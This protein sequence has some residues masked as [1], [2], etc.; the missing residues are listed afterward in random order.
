MTAKE[1]FYLVSSMRDAQ[2]RYFQTRD[3]EVF[4][5]ARKLENLVDEEIERTHQVLN[6]KEQINYDLKTGTGY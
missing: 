1:F 5:A 3:R 2:R 6:V 4:R